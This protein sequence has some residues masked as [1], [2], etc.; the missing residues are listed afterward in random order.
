MISFFLGVLTDMNIAPRGEI[1]KHSAT[2]R[3]CGGSCGFGRSHR[4]SGVERTKSRP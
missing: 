4:G 3:V 2:L 1:P